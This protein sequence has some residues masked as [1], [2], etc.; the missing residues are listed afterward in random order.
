M[1]RFD[2][3]SSGFVHFPR[4]KLTTFL[5]LFSHIFLKEFN[6]IANVSQILMNEIRDFMKIQGPKF[7]VKCLSS[8]FK[9]STF[10]AFEKDSILKLFSRCNRICFF[11]RDMIENC[12][13]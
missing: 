13:H 10:K 6:D 5:L 12:S 4:K 1:Q 9:Y 2:Y 7:H 11:S 8:H 3:I